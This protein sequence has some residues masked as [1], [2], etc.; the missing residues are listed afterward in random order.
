MMQDAD[1]IDVVKL[2]IDAADSSGRSIRALTLIGRRS[3]TRACGRG[4]SGY[5]NHPSDRLFAP[6]RGR[7]RPRFLN[8]SGHGVR[9]WL[10]EQR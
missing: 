3:C 5:R 6:G 2:N 7:L 8:S 1:K 9:S 4:E 10:V